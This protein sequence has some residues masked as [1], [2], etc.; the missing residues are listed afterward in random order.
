[1]SINQF[2]AQSSDD[3]LIPALL[4]LA[5]H[6]CDAFPTHGDIQQFGVFLVLSRGM[7]PE[8]VAPIVC[9]LEDAI[10]EVRRQFGEDKRDHLQPA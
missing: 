1:M 10:D 7:T 6:V 4:E 3:G 2:E 9:K 8:Q 5:Y